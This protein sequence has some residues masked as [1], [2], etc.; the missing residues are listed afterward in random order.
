VTT[1]LKGEHCK[2]NAACRYEEDTVVQ[3]EI[4]YNMCLLLEKVEARNDVVEVSWCMF[5]RLVEADGF[6]IQREE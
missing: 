1:S 3:Q 4:G 2:K 5:T 6:A